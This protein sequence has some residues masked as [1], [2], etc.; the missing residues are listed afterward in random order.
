MMPELDENIFIINND[1][2]MYVPPSKTDGIFKSLRQ[3]KTWEPRVTKG[4]LYEFNEK[5]IDTFIDIG[6]NIGYYTL[7]L[8]NKN[9]KTYSFEPNLEN[10]NILTKNLKINNFN[11]CQHYNLGLSDSIGELEFYYRKEKSGH[12]SFNKK[13]VKQQ[14]LNLCKII[15]VN[16]IDNIDIQGKNIMVKMDIEG[17]ELNAIMGMLQLLDS[18]KIK[19]FCIEIS[20]KFYG[21]DVEKE[22]INLLKKYFTKLYIV[23]LKRQL[24]EIPTLSQYDLICS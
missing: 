4:M 17:Y 12:G 16:K 23:Q 7:L 8:A 2:K 10:Y 15:K 18:K 20:R 5:K 3:K 1:F 21:N 9:I 6:A 13:I 19:V 24:I 22:I 11:N 14:N